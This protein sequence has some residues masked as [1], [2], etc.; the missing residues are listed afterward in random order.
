MAHTFSK[1]D[2]SPSKNT[3]DKKSIGKDWGAETDAANAP[4][5]PS[6]SQRKYWPTVNSTDDYCDGDNDNRPYEYEED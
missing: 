4:N 3:F 5:T 2:V 1:G 6:M